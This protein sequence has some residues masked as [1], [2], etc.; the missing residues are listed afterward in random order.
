MVGL[1]C[2]TKQRIVLLGLKGI[3]MNVFVLTVKRQAEQSRR[4]LL[5]DLHSSDLCHVNEEEEHTTPSS[6]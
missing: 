1:V 6:T 4:Q 5:F 3:Q 2:Q